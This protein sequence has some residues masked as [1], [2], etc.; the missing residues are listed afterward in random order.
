[1]APKNILP[2]LAQVAGPEITGSY[3]SAV[4][5]LDIGDTLL[6]DAGS[7]FKFRQTVTNI[8][9]AGHSP[10]ALSSILLTH[11]HYDHIGAAPLFRK[12]LGIPLVM[13]EKD[14]EIIARGDSRLSAAIC[15]R[16]ELEPFPIDRILTGSEGAVSFGDREISWIHTP[17]HTPGSISPYLDQDG[18]RILFGQDISAPLLEYY[19]CDP[20]AWAESVDKLTAL[21]ADIFC[22]GHMGPIVGKRK[23][24]EYLKY[25]L[26]AHGGK[27]S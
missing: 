8:K 19:D 10:S 11:C 18:L 6:I 14:A 3:D 1:M 2:N 21:D 15:F 26:R 17:G 23:V 27:A 9:M 16:V 7:G 24:R 5:L 12:H 25:V 4:Y 22:D 13:H 20:S